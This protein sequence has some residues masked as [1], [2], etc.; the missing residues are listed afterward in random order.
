MHVARTKDGSNLRSYGEGSEC[1]DLRVIGS[2]IHEWE[3]G[4]IRMVCYLTLRLNQV[5]CNWEQEKRNFF[6]TCGVSK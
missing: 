6:L 4:N 5:V 3:L 1:M 2:K